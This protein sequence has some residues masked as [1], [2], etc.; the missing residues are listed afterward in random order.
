[1]TPEIKELMNDCKGSFMCFYEEKEKDAAIGKRYRR[2][3]A[4]DTPFCVTIDL[5]RREDKFSYDTLPGYNGAG[6]D[7]VE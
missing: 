3:D 7:C 6:K 2:M 4:I 5:R 1:M